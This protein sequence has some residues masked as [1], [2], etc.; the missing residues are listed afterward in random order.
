MKRLIFILFFAIGVL[1]AVNELSI[2]SDDQLVPNFQ[3]WYNPKIGGC[4]TG[5]TVGCLMKPPCY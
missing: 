5:G 1:F 3:C 4:D 2:A